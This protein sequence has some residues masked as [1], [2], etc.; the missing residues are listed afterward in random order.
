MFA[1]A[2]IRGREVFV[3]MTKTMTLSVRLPEE[4]ASF[5]AGLTIEGAA[6]P[7]DKLRAII[8]DARLRTQITRSYEDAHDQLQSLMRPI[9]Q[10]VRSAENQ[11]GLHSEVVERA[12]PWL[13]EAVAFT[14]SVPLETHKQEEGLLRLEDGIAIRIFRLFEFALRMASTASA[15]G[16]DKAV[17]ERQL[18]GIKDLLKIVLLRMEEK[19]R[20]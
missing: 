12:L 2:Y 8:R 16:Y 4:D 14:V 5:I 9:M 1:N 20:D 3:I 15:P 17:M 10:A 19:T 13:A 18:D 7:S 6:T 11:T